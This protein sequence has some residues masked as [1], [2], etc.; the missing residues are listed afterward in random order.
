MRAHL[1]SWC[2][3]VFFK[4]TVIKTFVKVFHGNKYR[5]AEIVHIKEEGENYELGK[6]KT[7]F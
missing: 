5:I 7:N 2:E 1:E 4:D 3:H 6:K